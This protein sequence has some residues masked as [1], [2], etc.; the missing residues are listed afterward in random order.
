MNAQA[1]PLD[2]DAVV[3][4]H[5]L[6]LVNQGASGLPAFY[7]PPSMPSQV[8]GWRRAAVWTVIT[9]LVSSA[10]AGICLT[11]GPDE[12]WRVLGVLFRG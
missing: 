3:D 4:P 11:Y 7:M 5:F 6:R 2:E 1:P 12:L 9:L 10:S 8:R